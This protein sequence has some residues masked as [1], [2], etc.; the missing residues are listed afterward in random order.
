MARSLDLG[1][2]GELEILHTPRRDKI[3]GTRESW[4]IHCTTWRC[5]AGPRKRR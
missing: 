5:H 2:H 4:P 3:E 1:E